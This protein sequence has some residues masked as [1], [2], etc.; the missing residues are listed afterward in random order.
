MPH[1]NFSETENAIIAKT[2]DTIRNRIADLVKDPTRVGLIEGKDLHIWARLKQ[3]ASMPRE[4]LIHLLEADYVLLCGCFEPFAMPGR[5]EIR[6]LEYP[7]YPPIS[8]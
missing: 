2:C 3:Y 5:S 7:E 8:H 6:V 1:V 4:E